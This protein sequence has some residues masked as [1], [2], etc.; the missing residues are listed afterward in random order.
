[1]PKRAPKVP[2]KRT[3]IS[4]PEDILEQGEKNAQTRG[5]RRS[6]SAYVAWLIEADNEGRAEREVLPHLSSP[7]TREEKRRG[8][9]PVRTTMKKPE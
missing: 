6:F 7:K 3:S 2:L 5:F 1:M 9:K 4:I 8:S